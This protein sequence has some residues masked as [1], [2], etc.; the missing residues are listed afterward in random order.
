MYYRSESQP[1]ITR[2]EFSLKG[3]MR[4]IGAGVFRFP[5]PGLMSVDRGEWIHLDQE[6]GMHFGILDALCP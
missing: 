5:L 2:Q 6:D 1:V 3:E 4:E